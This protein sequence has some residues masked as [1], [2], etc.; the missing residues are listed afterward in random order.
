MFF[1]IPILCEVMRKKCR[2]DKNV[3]SFF[4]LLRNKMH[5]NEI[6]SHLDVDF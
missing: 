3:L 4:M 5:L 6:I 2:Y 1:E